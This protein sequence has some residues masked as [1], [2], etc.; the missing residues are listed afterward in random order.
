MRFLQS[1]FQGS[2][3]GPC[4]VIED[5]YVHV[6]ISYSRIIEFLLK[7][8][9]SPLP[10]FLRQQVTETGLYSNKLSIEPQN[11]DEFIEDHGTFLKIGRLPILGI[12][13]EAESEQLADSNAKHCRE[14]WTCER[15]ICECA[16]TLG[17][18]VDNST[19]KIYRSALNSYLNFIKMHDYPLEPLPD[20]LSLFTVYMCHH[21]KPDSVGTYLSGICHQLEPYFP[22]V[23]TSRNSA[24]VHCTLQGYK[25]IRAT[26]TSQKQALTINNLETVVDALSSSTD[27]DDCLFL[28]Q[29][30]TRFFALFRLGEMMYPDDASLRDPRKVTKRSSVHVDDSSYK[31]FLPGHKADRFF[32]GNTIIV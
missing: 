22:N 3:D 18:A 17:Q 9:P 10:S 11:F 12:E 4:L 24:L 25:R 30:L 15:L 23:R 2:G 7:D 28:A 29:L 14:V 21:I 26:P 32:E 16:I 27:Y 20:T 31:M 6:Y 19:W 5:T 1:S 13:F 8:C